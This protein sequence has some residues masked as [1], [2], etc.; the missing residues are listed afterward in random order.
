MSPW[1]RC[2]QE[3]QRERRESLLSCLCKD[4]GENLQIQGWAACLGWERMPKEKHPAQ[5]QTKSFLHP[6]QSQETSFLHIKRKQNPLL[7]LLLSDE[8]RFSFTLQASLS[9]QAAQLEFWA[10]DPEIS[11]M[12]DKPLLKQDN[13]IISVFLLG[14]PRTCLRSHRGREWSS[15]CSWKFLLGSQGCCVSK[16]LLLLSSSCRSCFFPG[17]FWDLPPSW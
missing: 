2:C 13:P 3:I 11:E 1:L 14:A 7:L 6:V 15:W 8:G 9:S 10:G 12:S 5:E 4:L 16:E 17:M